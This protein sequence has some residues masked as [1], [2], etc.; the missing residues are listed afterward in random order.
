[1]TARDVVAW[2]KDPE[3]SL[4]SKSLGLLALLY[5]LSPVDLCPDVIPV[6]GWLDDVGVLGLVAAFYA[7]RIS[8]HAARRREFGQGS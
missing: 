6:I 2:L 8:A 5:V 3:V 1:M 4:A 7:R